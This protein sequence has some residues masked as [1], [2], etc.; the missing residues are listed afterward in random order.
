MEQSPRGALFRLVWV[1]VQDR[2]PD[3]SASRTAGEFKIAF[4]KG[5]IEEKRL[6]FRI[7]FSESKQSLLSVCYHLLQA[8]RYKYPKAN[9]VH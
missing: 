3:R 6:F 9:S 8:D 2:A 1:F 7:S 5:I 4:A